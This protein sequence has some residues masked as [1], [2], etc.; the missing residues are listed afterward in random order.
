MSTAI[1]VQHADPQ[2]PV[3]VTEAAVRHFRQQILAAKAAGLRLSVKESGCTGYMYV[4]DLVEAPPADD[5]LMQLADDVC[6][7][8]DR[9]SLPILRGTTVDFVREGLN[10]LLR[11]GNPNAKD[12]CG[13]GESFSIDGEARA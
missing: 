4:M 9:A 12:Y 13:C 11:F 7:W 2:L 10:S 5:L 1:E 8:I 3:E 6:L